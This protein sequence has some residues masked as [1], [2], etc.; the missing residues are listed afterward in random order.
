MVISTKKTA[1][2]LAAAA[3]L[4]ALAQ[5][6]P[7]TPSIAIKFGA[8]EPGR[9]GDT[10]GAVNGAAGVLGTVNWNNMSGGTQATPQPLTADVAGTALALPTTTVAWSSAGTWSSTGR[11]EENNTGTGE[12][13]DLMAGYLD[14]GTV[15]EMGVSITVAGLPPVEGLPLF[16]VY[17][18][19]QGGVNGRGGNYTIAPTTMEHVGD[20]GFAGTFAEDTLDPG[21]TPGSNYLV[22]RGLSGSGFTLTSTPTTGSS[23]TDVARAPINAIE[24]VAAPIP[25]PATIALVG[26]GAS[27]L[28]LRRRRA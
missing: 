15:E 1:I 14:T 22:F 19:I 11:G 16:D 12:N 5:A 7:T 25:E 6:A 13:G 28:L 20:T 24:I 2:A 8:N 3:A 17:V 4:G 23:A 9:P 21:T 26:L 10:N 18:Y 27:A